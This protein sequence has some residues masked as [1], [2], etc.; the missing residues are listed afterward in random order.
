VYTL[1]R[2][3]QAALARGD[4]ECAGLLGAADADGER[5]PSWAGERERRGGSL[6][7]DESPE[8][9]ASVEQG[10][11]LDLW[12]AAALALGELDEPEDDAQT[13]P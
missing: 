6:S 8:L 11:T 13:V 9:L 7:T 5:T 3:A 1:A 4:L 2:L 12:H 10:R